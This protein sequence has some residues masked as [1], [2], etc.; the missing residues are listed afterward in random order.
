MGDLE[1]YW[2]RNGRTYACQRLGR[3]VMTVCSLQSALD[4]VERV[5]VGLRQLSLGMKI[6]VCLLKTSNCLGDL[7]LY[8]VQPLSSSLNLALRVGKVT[9]QLGNPCC[10]SLGWRGTHCSRVVQLGLQLLESAI[11]FSVDVACEFLESAHCLESRFVLD[12][13]LEREGKEIEGRRQSFDNTGTEPSAWLIQGDKTSKLAIERKTTH[14]ENS[15]LLLRS[16]S[17]QLHIVVGLC[18]EVSYCGSK[19]ERAANRRRQVIDRNR[20]RCASDASC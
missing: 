18:T 14:R 12:D 4:L 7:L 13:P 11:V 2:R 9:L 17:K 16:Y 19:V 1:R 10:I 15:T 5:G 6:Y 20:E 3:I 8:G